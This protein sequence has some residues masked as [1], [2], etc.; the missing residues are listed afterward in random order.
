VSRV[1]QDPVLAGILEA[2]PLPGIS[3]AK[4]YILTRDRKHWFVRKAA[5]LPTDS[6]RLR[7]Q[8]EK[9]AR[10]AGVAAGLLR[11]PAILADGEIE[12]RYYFDME[13]VRGLDGATYLRRAPFADVIRF[14]DRLGEYLGWAAGQTAL[15]GAGSLPGFEALFAKLCEIQR[16]TRMLDERVL[17]RLLVALDR[18]RTEGPQTPSLCHGDLTLE[19]MVL[20]EDGII[21]VI[22]LLNPPFEH[23]WHDVAKLHQ[24]LS[25]GWFL[26]HQ[27]EVARSVTEYVSGRVIARAVELSPAY[28]RLH[29]TLVACNFARILPYVATDDERGFVT[30]RIDHFVAQ[31]GHESTS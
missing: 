14:S 16:Q 28:R 22:D 9:Q 13:F 12:G 24:D 31:I 29:A 18:M 27:P 10:F 17:A 2:R 19:N 11:T 26:R 21:W 6:A 20:G 25:G 3:R 1:P 5:R 4:V 15:T 7:T 8:A 23:W 30:E